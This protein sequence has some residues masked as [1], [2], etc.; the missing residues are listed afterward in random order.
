MA[1]SYAE[2]LRDPRWQ[3]KRLQIMERA[4]FACEHCGAADRTL[5]VHH[6]LYRKGAMPWEYEN[7]ELECVCEGC[8]EIAH[9]WR[10][11][12]DEI[13]AQSGDIERIVGFA[14]AMLAEQLIFEEDEDGNPRKDQW[15]MRSHE[16]AWGF[17]SAL[18]GRPTATEID[19]IIDLSPLSNTDVF[20]LG[21]HNVSPLDLREERNEGA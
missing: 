11:R 17:L 16:H 8:H 7:H 21:P 15:P 6:K 10:Q 20:A 4:D 9:G 12:L 2:K 13:L 18:R 5:N 19:A 1:K 3:R 14:E